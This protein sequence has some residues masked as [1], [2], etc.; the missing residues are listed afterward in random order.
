MLAWAGALAVVTGLVFLLVIA[1]SRGWIGEAERT[2]LAGATSLLLLAAGVRLHER[3][4]RTDAALAAAAAGVAGLFGTLTVAGAVYDLV[5]APLALAGALATG[6]AATA[7][8]VRWRAPGMAALG[9]VGALL[10][11]ALVGAMPTAAGVAVLAIATA[12]AAAVVVWQRWTWLAFATFAL[13]TPQWLAWVLLERPAPAATLAALV[14]FGALGAAAAVGF[15]LRAAEPRLRISSAVLLVLNALVLAAAGWWAL[16]DAV[17]Q[18]AGHAWLAALAAAHLAV[19]LGAA[20][21]RRVSHELALAA[22][23]LGI[24]LADIAVASVLDGCRCSGPTRSRA[25]PSPRCC[26]AGSPG[27]A[28]SR[29]PPPA[30]AATCCSRSATRSCSTRRATAS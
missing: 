22:L 13:A 5:P 11:P 2:L 6:A 20:R 19:G 24:V 17:S 16:S 28:T 7:L 26:A 21:L 27:A 30:W 8:A 15:E 29:S 1:V 9:I 23:A 4:G 25:P 14:A 10:S 18:T 3:R 12:S